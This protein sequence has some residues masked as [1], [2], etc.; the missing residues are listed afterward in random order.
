MSRSSVRPSPSPTPS[1]PNVAEESPRSTPR[2]SPVKEPGRLFSPDLSSPAG[3]PGVASPG[4]IH[5]TLSNGSDRRRQRPLH[6]RSPSYHHTAFGNIDAPP[7]HPQLRTRPIPQVGTTT[8]LWAHTR[9]IARFAPSTSYIPPDP[10]LPLRSRL[11]HQPIGSGSLI[12]SSEQDK[13]TLGSRWALNFGTGTIGHQ[14]R[15]SLTGSLFGL[16]KSMVG[17]AAGGSLEEERRRVWN[18]HDLPVLETTRSLMG[19]DI[20]LGEGETKECK[21]LNPWTAS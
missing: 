20:K 4:S 12:P 14:T 15:P 16:A 5:S 18:T 10:L 7:L 6:A 11:L 17:G 19:V 3:S 13:S 8:V 2:S 21:Q 9:L 1:L